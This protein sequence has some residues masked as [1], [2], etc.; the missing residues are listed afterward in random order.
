[1]DG[2]WNS[3]IDDLLGQI[4]TLMDVSGALGFQ[5][6]Q[7][8]ALGD[9][10]LLPLD[11]DVEPF[12]PLIFNFSIFDAV[13]PCRKD[14]IIRRLYVAIYCFYRPHLVKL[15]EDFQNTL[16]LYA[17][18]DVDRLFDGKVGSL[19][20]PG[21]VDHLFSMDQIFSLSNSL[22]KLQTF[23]TQCLDMINCILEMVRIE[24]QEERDFLLKLMLLLC[25]NCLGILQASYTTSTSSSWKYG[26]KLLSTL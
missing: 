21:K 17:S 14:D 4:S 11:L 19:A 24:K 25:F 1:M 13:F 22:N 8:V 16:A 26:S 20:E 9:P 12:E 10:L 15:K 5:P 6:I 18:L 2:K 23:R 3:R 7:K